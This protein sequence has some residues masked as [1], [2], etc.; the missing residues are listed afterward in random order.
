MPAASFRPAHPKHAY[1]LLKSGAPTDPR[2]DLE[3]RKADMG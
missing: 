2:T 3:T 1:R